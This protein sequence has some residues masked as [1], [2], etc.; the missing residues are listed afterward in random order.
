MLCG[1]ASN[2]DGSD[3]EAIVSEGVASGLDSGFA[4]SE[5]QIWK[6]VKSEGWADVFIRSDVEH[7]PQLGVHYHVGFTS[8]EFAWQGNAPGRYNGFEV[9]N[10]ILYYRYA[11][12]TEFG[13]A[14]ADSEGNTVALLAAERD[15]YEN[16][17]N[18]D[19]TLDGDG[20]VY[21]AYVVGTAFGSTLKIEKQQT[22]HP[23]QKWRAYTRIS[24]RSARYT[25]I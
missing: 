5:I 17:L 15:G 2:T 6:Y 10:N 9:E 11:D 7:R 19:F 13:V 14:R 1:V 20:N 8:R 16:H 21:L 12:E 23:Q 3:T 18:F 4:A 25:K 22:V 24:W